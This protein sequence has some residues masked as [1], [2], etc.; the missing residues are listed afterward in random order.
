MWILIVTSILV[1]IL[2]TQRKLK[3]LPLR[4]T[5]QFIP[6]LKSPFVDDIESNDQ[7]EVALKLKETIK[8]LFV[9]DSFCELSLKAI[10]DFVFAASQRADRAMFFRG[11]IQKCPL[12]IYEIDAVPCILK[13]S[14]KRIK[15]QGG[16]CV[17]EIIR[18][19]DLK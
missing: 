4:P 7:F 10:P 19:I 17:E 6:V 11:D 3:T 13:I 2:F 12:L 8:Y 14:D 16:F 9:Y 5:L 18:F 1:F 15:F